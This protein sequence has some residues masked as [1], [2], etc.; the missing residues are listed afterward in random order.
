MSALIVFMLMQP[1]QN[2][3][4]AVNSIIGIAGGV[5]V[6]ATSGEAQHQCCRSGG[7]E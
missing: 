7:G 3:A 2:E 4:Y 1:A 5:A 6:P